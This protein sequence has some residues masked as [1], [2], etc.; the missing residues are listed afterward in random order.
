MTH[1]ELV[2]KVA[3]AVYGAMRF[4]RDGETFAWVN[5]GNSFAQMKARRTAREAIRIVGEACTSEV[6]SALALDENL[7]NEVDFAIQS[8]TQGEQT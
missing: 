4:D 6:I 7:A 1:E 3:E 2:E 8:L 5:H